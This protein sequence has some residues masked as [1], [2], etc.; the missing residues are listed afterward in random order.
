M[1]EGRRCQATTGGQSM[2]CYL[3]FVAMTISASG[4]KTNR[5]FNKQVGIHGVGVT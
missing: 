4:T 5:H 3:S 1:K 2:L